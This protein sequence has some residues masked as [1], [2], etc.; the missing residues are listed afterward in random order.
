MNTDCG[1]INLKLR[2]GL[3]SRWR[4]QKKCIDDIDRCFGK[5]IYIY[6]TV[7]AYIYIRIYIYVHI[8]VYTYTYIFIYTYIKG[9]QMHGAMLSV[10]V[11]WR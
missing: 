5:D 11:E 8:Y 6:I 7:P 3:V 2:Q 1:V 9:W 10:V 4:L